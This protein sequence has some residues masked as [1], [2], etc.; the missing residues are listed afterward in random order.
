M[1]NDV[2]ASWSWCSVR[3]L[4]G[5]LTKTAEKIIYTSRNTYYIGNIDCC[6]IGKMLSTQS[7]SCVALKWHEY[8]SV[9]FSSDNNTQVGVDEPYNLQIGVSFEF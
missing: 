5:C 2:V 1:A 9:G 6:I 8:H 7:D 4:Q 3:T